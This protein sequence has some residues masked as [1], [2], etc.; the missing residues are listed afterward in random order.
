MAVHFHARKPRGGFVSADGV[1]VAPEFGIAQEVPRRQ[2]DAEHYQRRGGDDPHRSV[3]NPLE[4]IRE[5][6][7]RPAVSDGLGYPV[8]ADHRA[9]GDNKGRHAPVCD[10]PALGRADQGPDQEA[11]E[12][13]EPRERPGQ[14]RNRPQPVFH[15]AG[16]DHPGQR[17]DR[18][19][20]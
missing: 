12:D 2:V 7:S 4:I 9:E 3:G 10:Q 18:T 13:R 15:Q 14:G 20:G 17:H 19:D 8:Q 16:G 6:V 5:G 1:A 11:D